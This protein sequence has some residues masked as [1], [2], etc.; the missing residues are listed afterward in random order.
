MKNNFDKL[1]FSTLLFAGLLPT[2]PTTCLAL[3]I[4]GGDYT[5]LPDGSN[6]ALLYYNGFV[7]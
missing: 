5:P 6:M 4:D 1:S 2:F 7:A 3:D